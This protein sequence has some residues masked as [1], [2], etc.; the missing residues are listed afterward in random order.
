MES[1]ITITITP[2]VHDALLIAIDMMND[3]SEIINDRE[4]PY[5]GEMIG[6]VRDLFSMILSG[7]MS[8]IT[9]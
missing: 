4:A 5:A 9:N 1:N 3:L 7:D 6:D 8:T 2:E